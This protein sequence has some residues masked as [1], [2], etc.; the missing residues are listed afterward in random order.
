MVLDQIH[1]AVGLVV[2][3][4]GQDAIFALAFIC[5]RQPDQAVNVFLIGVV[6][7]FDIR[8]AGI[9]EK[10]EPL[11][12][13]AAAHLRIHESVFDAGADGEHMGVEIDEPGWVDAIEG[14]VDE[15]FSCD[16]RPFVRDPRVFA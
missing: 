3:V 9:N 8:C 10:L 4:E 14:L 6:D 13:D 1:G 11:E 15:S 7:I 16:P 12:I 2:F 5:P